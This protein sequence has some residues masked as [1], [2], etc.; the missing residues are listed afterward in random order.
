MQTSYTTL[1]GPTIPAKGWT[2][3]PPSEARLAATQQRDG[4]PSITSS[5][6]PG[7]WPHSAT[8]ACS[9][10]TQ[11]PNVFVTPGQTGI[12]STGNL[13]REQ[14]ALA[15]RQTSCKQ[16][17]ADQFAGNT[18]KAPATASVGSYISATSAEA[19]TLYQVQRAPANGQ[20]PKLSSRSKF[21]TKAQGRGQQSQ[22][23]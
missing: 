23:H 3:T 12:Q 8:V 1:P 10:G 22:P 7:L 20:R 14:L 13:A 18:I 6:R 15:S 21:S 11:T 4:M 16:S 2:M 17:V 5:G 19:T 9:T